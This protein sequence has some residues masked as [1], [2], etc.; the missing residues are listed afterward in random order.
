LEYGSSA[1]LK[2]PDGKATPFLGLDDVYIYSWGS[3]GSEVILE[4]DSLIVSKGIVV[5]NEDPK[6]LTIEGGTIP[7]SVIQPGDTATIKADATLK[8]AAGAEFILI[9]STGDNPKATLNVEAKGTIEV[10]GKFTI[11]S[12]ATGDLDGT[13][14]VKS[15]GI[16]YDL[17][18]GGGSLWTANATGT[19][20]YEYGS[21]AYIQ[22]SSSP[23]IRIGKSGDNDDKDAKY[24]LESG[25][26]F[27]LKKDKY[28]LQGVA[29]GDPWGVSEG[30][31]FEI[32]EGGVYTVADNS[33]LVLVSAG[34]TGG[35]K[36]IGPGK[37]VIGSTEISGGTGGWQAVGDGAITIHRSGVTASIWGK[38]TLKGG[39]DAT[40]TQK[41]GSDNVLNI[42]SIDNNENANKLTLDLGTGAS[43][44]LKSG[45]DPGK[46]VIP[47]TTSSILL[48]TG[49]GTSAAV[50]SVPI[51]IEGK[52]TLNTNFIAA[53]YQVVSNKLVKIGG[54]TANG[55][56]TASTAA[57]ADVTI[58]A[59]ATVAV[60]GGGGA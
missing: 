49:T 41:A 11:Q 26:E 38:T 13:I 8:I 50:S 14:K 40:I 33:A 35:G 31:T 37:V 36:L 4:K 55:S 58:N 42:G 28:I 47:Y 43:I 59:G 22:S 51:Q 18:S 46:I 15:G 53:D 27:S 32:L 3:A 45:T 48:G 25:A 54:T 57:N 39:T 6:P 44:V 34:D 7:H 52:N 23:V 9:G 24:K 21:K 12:G 60:S 17:K 1:K 19:F 16:T 2:A 56:I 10:A 20:V 30:M 5:V 29:S